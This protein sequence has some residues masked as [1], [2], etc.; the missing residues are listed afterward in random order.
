M[1][2]PD[3]SNRHLSLK[4]KRTCSS[5]E[6]HE[7]GPQTD[8]DE[9]PADG[10]IVLSNLVSL[11]LD[12]HNTLVGQVREGSI[13][14]GISRLFRLRLRDSKGLWIKNRFWI[15]HRKC[16]QIQRILGSY[17]YSECMH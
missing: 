15:P 7:G 8:Q 17:A 13:K 10:D 14:K 2:L 6:H 3:P 16:S 1:Q 11:V 9:K 5:L 4:T 12:T